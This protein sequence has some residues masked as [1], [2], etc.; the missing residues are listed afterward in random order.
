[1]WRKLDTKET[2]RLEQAYIA[3]AN[4]SMSI[5]RLITCTLCCLCAIV[6]YDGVQ[7]SQMDLMHTLIV[8]GVICSIVIVYIIMY[9]RVLYEYTALLKNNARICEAK[10]V[11]KDVNETNKE[12]RLLVDIHE[13]NQITHCWVKVPK[14]TYDNMTRYTE[15]L[16]VKFDNGNHVK[17]AVFDKDLE[18]TYV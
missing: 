15:V 6:I 11:N 8:F 9:M 14:Q 4:L 16:V 7:L 1:M 12:Y 18:Y 3:G 2:L 5:I 13:F 17:M 10:I